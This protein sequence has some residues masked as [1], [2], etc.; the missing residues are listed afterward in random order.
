[1]L[2]LADPSNDIAYAFLYNNT[3]VDTHHAREQDCS[4]C[5]WAAHS[6]SVEK[7]FAM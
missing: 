4:S 7:Y 2:I 3:G 6:L 1:M 5:F